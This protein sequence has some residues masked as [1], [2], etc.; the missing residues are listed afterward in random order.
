M[1]QTITTGFSIVRSAKINAIIIFSLNENRKIG[2]LL[3]QM[4]RI[5]LGEIVTEVRGRNGDLP[6]FYMIVCR[7]EY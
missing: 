2:S 5:N 7:D 3:K 4:E 6:Y 1:L